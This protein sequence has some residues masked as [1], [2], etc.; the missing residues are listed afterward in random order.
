MAGFLFYF[1]ELDHS[2]QQEGWQTQRAYVLVL[3][4]IHLTHLK[5]IGTTISVKQ[6]D[7]KPGHPISSGVTKKDPEP[8]K[9]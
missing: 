9:D 8:G 3:K 4:I 7:E 1:S 5:S 6:Q 2:V